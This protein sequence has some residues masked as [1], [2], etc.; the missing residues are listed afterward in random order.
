MDCGEGAGYI[1][2]SHDPA[3]LLHRV[4]IRGK[5]TMHSENLFVDDGGNRQTVETIRKG[6]P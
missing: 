3:N 4:E 6:L 2:R 5:T 1:S